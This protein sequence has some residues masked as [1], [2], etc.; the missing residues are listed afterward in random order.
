[1]NTIRNPISLPTNHLMPES[2]PRF[3]Q[4]S[5]VTYYGTIHLVIT[6][7]QRLIGVTLDAGELADGAVVRP[8]E[9]DR[10]TDAGLPVGSA[11]DSSGLHLR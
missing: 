11:A 6:S 1:M 9:P 3:E 7:D 4:D 5:V 10:G 8:I 2:C